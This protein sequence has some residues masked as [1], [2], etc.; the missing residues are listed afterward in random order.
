[1]APGDR[2]IIISY[3]DYSDAELHRYV[4]RIVH[5]NSA[6]EP[7]DEELASALAGLDQPAPRRFVE[8]D[9]AFRT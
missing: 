4:P 9:A 8:V 7:I 1:V 6:N 5:V 3:A 2:V